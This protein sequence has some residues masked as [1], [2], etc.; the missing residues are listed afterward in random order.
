M[1][2]KSVKSLSTIILL[3]CVIGCHSSYNKIGTIITRNP[4]L[5]KALFY[6][7][8]TGDKRVIVEAKVGDEHYAGNI[9][10]ANA[11]RGL[12]KRYQSILRMTSTKGTLVECYIENYSKK[13]AKGGEGICYSRNQRIYDITLGVARHDTMDI[14]SRSIF[15]Y[16]TI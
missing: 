2:K 11:P 14:K 12:N 13:I 9:T 4:H 8:V 5:S 6:Y 10:M 7:Y 15:R 1:L 16:L 3:L